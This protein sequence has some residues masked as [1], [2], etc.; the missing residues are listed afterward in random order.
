MYIYY[1]GDGQLQVLRQLG[2]LRKGL[3]LISKSSIRNSTILQAVSLL[4]V[5]PVTLVLLDQIGFVRAGRF[6]P[7]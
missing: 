1:P 4:L 5:N 2:Y 3:A 6:L 7:R